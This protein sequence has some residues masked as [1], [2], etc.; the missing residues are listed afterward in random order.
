[1]RLAARDN[2]TRVATATVITRPPSISGIH[3]SAPVRAVVAPAVLLELELELVLE[4]VFELLFEL[5]LE[6]D[7]CAEA[8]P[9]N[10]SVITTARKAPAKIR[11]AIEPVMCTLSPSPKTRLSGGPEFVTDAPK[12]CSCRHRPS[13]PGSP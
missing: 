13:Y 3:I 12:S 6:L 10:D 9:A 5:E 11:R 7:D 8:T 2:P 1:M 4:L